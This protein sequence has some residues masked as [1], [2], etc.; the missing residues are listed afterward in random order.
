V[1]TEPETGY[2]YIK[3]GELLNDVVLKQAKHDTESFT[4]SVF[5][6]NQMSKL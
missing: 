4:V 1:P 2:G 5:V 6:K 3:R